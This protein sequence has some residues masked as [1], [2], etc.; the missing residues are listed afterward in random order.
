VRKK[1]GRI[2]FRGLW[3]ISKDG[4]T[5]HD[6]YTEFCD[7]SGNAARTFL[8]VLTLVGTHPPQEFPL[9]LPLASPTKEYSKEALTQAWVPLTLN[10]TTGRFCPS[11]AF[12][13]TGLPTPFTTVAVIDFLLWCGSFTRPCIA[14]PKLLR[15]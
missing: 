4:A 5:V 3:K 12:E 1:D 13:S 10:I 15:A 11:G 9:E 7:G 8:Y 6:G 14:N 2:E